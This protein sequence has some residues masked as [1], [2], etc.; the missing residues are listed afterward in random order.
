MQAIAAKEW[1][2]RCLRRIMVLLVYGAVISIDFTRCTASAQP[3]PDYDLAINYGTVMDPAS[4]LQ[5]VRHLG[6]RNRRI[7]VIA[8]APVAARQTIDA[9][10]LVVAPGFIDLHAH[11][12]DRFSSRLQALDGVTTALELELG[13]M[14]VEAWYAGRAGKAIINYGVA[15]SHINARAAV[16]GDTASTVYGQATAAELDRLESLLQ[17]GLDDGALGIGYG[18][19]YTPGAGRDEIER[20]FRLAARNNVINFVHVRFA[21]AIEPGSS[22]E[23]VQEM[24]ACAASSGTGVHIVHIGSSGLHQVPLLLELIGGARSRGIDVST[25]VYPYTAASTSI[26]AALFDPGWRQRLGADFGDLEWVATGERLTAESFAAY[27]EQGGMVIAHIIPEAMVRHALAHPLVMVASDGVP[28]IDGRAHP[29]GAGTFARVLGHYARDQQVL[30]QMQ[31]LAKMTIMPARRLE[32]TVPAMRRKGRISA[33]ADA[34]LTIFDAAKII[35]RATFAE[36]AQPSAGIRHVLV[37]GTFVVREGKFVENVYP[38][39]PIR[40]PRWPQEDGRR[41]EALSLLGQ[42]LYPMSF[43]PAQIAALDSQLAVA[44]AAFEANPNNEDNIIWYGRRTAYQSRYRDAIAIY[45]DGLRRFPE[46]YKLLRHRGHR[47]ISVREFDNAIADL[48]RASELIRGVPDEIEPDGQPNRL[49]I[50]TST[51]HFNIWYHLG[52]AYYLRG[53]FESALDAYRHC[54]RFS[55]NPDALVA[56][57][58]WLYMTLRRLGRET[59][60]VAALAPISEDLQIIENHAYFNRLLLYKGLK[61]A[62]S[63][64][65]ADSDDAL[66]VATYGYGIGNWYLYNGEREKAT[67]IFR[68]VIEGRFWPAFGYIAAEAELQRLEEN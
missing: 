15:V 36:P 62:D 12:Q 9:R 50:P 67:A 8:E 34:D 51:S 22:V 35:D 19:Q 27:R 41:A 46:S 10:G 16:K 48:R 43:T 60:A 32:A 14:P 53:D 25:E 23:A 13:A 4:G 47:Y 59:E 45:S 2:L 7:E 39:Q 26:K 52:L 29:R 49:N 11:G 56:T 42:P 37:A 54:L 28:F 66:Q 40:R 17:K 24:I 30:P 3:M 44:R 65:H 57:T 5:A 63:L 31:A 38:G 55:T 58:D 61:S 64:L 21:G 33:G 68:K 18:I 6:I 20:L 1:I